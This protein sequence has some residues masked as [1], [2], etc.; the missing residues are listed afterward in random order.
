MLV[1]TKLRELE[2]KG[3]N[4]DSFGSTKLKRNVLST[5]SVW[6]IV[7]M[8]LVYFSN[9]NQVFAKDDRNDTVQ[10]SG[11]DLIDSPTTENNQVN[12]IV[13]YPI[14]SN[15]LY[16]SIEHLNSALQIISEY[17]AYARA[18]YPS[19]TLPV[20]ATANKSDY[21]AQSLRL[22]Q[23]KLELDKL[24]SNARQELTIKKN[25]GDDL[26]IN[27]HEAD[28]SQRINNFRQAMNLILQIYNKLGALELG[29]NR[30]KLLM[31]SE[32]YA[33]EMLK[34]VDKIYSDSFLY[35]PSSN[36][37]LSSHNFAEMLFGITGKKQL[38]DYLTAQSQR[39]SYIAFN[40]A[41]PII[42]FMANMKGAA[43]ESRLFNKWK[44]SLIALHKQRYQ[45]PDNSQNKIERMFTIQL[46][47]T[48]KGNCLKQIKLVQI[49][50]END[51]FSES[52]NRIIRSI[53]KHCE[54]LQIDNTVERNHSTK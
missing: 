8:S 22:K 17:E 24:F 13:K 7:L 1:E 53:K 15:A 40:Y 46:L 23:L 6:P 14:N 25:L 11:V 41:E 4:S 27:Q 26:L 42:T 2:R 33:L 5:K 50:R 20:K 28:V 48:N 31:T 19:P 45:E 9:T 35:S 49:N 39:A 18:H 43:D 34:G 29:E 51:I 32:N 10:I 38:T 3:A 47:N 52:M 21:Q 12:Q 54:N 37:T 30:K 36:L 44:N 16:W